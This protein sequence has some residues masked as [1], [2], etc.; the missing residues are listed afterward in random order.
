MTRKV[1]LLLAALLVS[2]LL[3]CTSSETSPVEGTLKIPNALGMGSTDDGALA[4]FVRV[5]NDSRCPEGVQCVRAGEAF[6][7]I[8]TTADNAA[9]VESRLEMVPQGTASVE[10]GRF[11]ITLLELRPDPPPVGGVDQSAYELLLRIEEN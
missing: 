5:E 8:R 1:A 4:E 2:A 9:P 7:V 10:V 11:T 3:A 6:V